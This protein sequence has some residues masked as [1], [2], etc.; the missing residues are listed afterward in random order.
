M[1]EICRYEGSTN[2]QNLVKSWK[3]KEFQIVSPDIVPFKSSLVSI[4]S[5]WR[6]H[7]NGLCGFFHT[8]FIEKI[9]AKYCENPAV[10]LTSLIV[11]LILRYSNVKI[12]VGRIHCVDRYY[13]WCISVLGTNR[14]M[15]P[16]P[17]RSI[18]PSLHR[19]LLGTN[20]A[21]NLLFW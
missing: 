5:P 20:V 17:S 3:K 6:A 13:I 11:L 16:S 7:L 12:V 21:E 14:V 1:S 18:T 15:S 9:L 19:Y 8:Q 2:D 4:C 10:Y